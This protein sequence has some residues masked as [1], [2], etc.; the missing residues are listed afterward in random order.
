[1]FLVAVFN[2]SVIEGAYV[3]EAIDGKRGATVDRIAGGLHGHP[4]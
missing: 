1:M 2:R 3:H 4:E